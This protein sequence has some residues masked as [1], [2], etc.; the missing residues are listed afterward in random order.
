MVHGLKPDI[1]RGI[2]QLL[3]DSNYYV[4]VFKE[5]KEIFEQQDT[6]PYYW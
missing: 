3:H 4:E 1:V 2:K 5:A 6:P